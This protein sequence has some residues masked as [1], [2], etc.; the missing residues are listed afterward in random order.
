MQ[1]QDK[2]A[3]TC[4]I[5][6]PP[7]KVILTAPAADFVFPHCHTGTAGMSS[8]LRFCAAKYGVNVVG[9]DVFL[10]VSLMLHKRNGEWFLWVRLPFR[11]YIEVG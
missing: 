8:P 9:Q 10:I 7:F 11:S 1:V 4:N 6:A 2:V 5:R 3:G